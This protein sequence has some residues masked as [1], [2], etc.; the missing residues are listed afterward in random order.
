MPTMKAMKREIHEKDAKI[1]ALEERVKTLEKSF[2]DLEQY[3]RRNSLRLCGVPETE[4]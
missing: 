1:H 2:D 4:G 3:T